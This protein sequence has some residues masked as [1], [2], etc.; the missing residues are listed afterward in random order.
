MAPGTDMKEYYGAI[1]FGLSD[2]Y[3]SNFSEYGRGYLPRGLDLPNQGF[4]D[5][6]SPK[7]KEDLKDDVVEDFK[8]PI[9]LIL[10]NSGIFARVNIAIGTKYGPFVGKWK[11]QPLD[12]RYAWEVS[13]RKIRLIM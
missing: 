12:G 3:L 7:D 6:K 8:L 10:K 4:M 13:A 11:T 2:T 9:D 5:P 1:D